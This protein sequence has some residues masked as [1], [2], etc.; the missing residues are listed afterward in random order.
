ME[1]RNSRVLVIGGNV[2]SS[3]S[4]T[5]EPLRR[6]GARYLRPVE[7]SDIAGAQRIFAHLKLR[8]GPIE[9]NALDNSPSIRA[10][11]GR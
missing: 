8:A 3:V 1:E 4:L 7:E 6:D 9:P 2:L 10:L 5:I 11:T